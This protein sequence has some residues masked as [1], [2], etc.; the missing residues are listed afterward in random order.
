MPRYRITLE[1]DGTPFVGW[2]TQT[3]GKSVQGAITDAIANFAGEATSVRGAGR[4]DAGVHAAGQVAHFDLARDWDPL[5]LREA[6]NHHLKAQLIAVLECVVAAP[7]FDARFSATGRAYLYRILD[8]R[9]PPALDR[10]RVWWQAKRL[11]AEAMHQAAQVLI[12]T[13]D[14]TTFRAAACQ[15]ASPIKTL[16]RLDV[17]R[18]GDEVHVHA[19]ARSFLHNQ[20]RSIVG[21]LKNV[22]HGRWTT[23]DLKRTLD[24]RD[25]A[26]CGPVAPPGGLYLVGVMYPE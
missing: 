21:S 5:K 19:A 12:G 14:F 26:A 15:A 16:D 6:L 22:G 1:Y 25:R 11:N 7:D 20:V 4:T 23:Q 3:N 13:H 10:N 18:R 24:A 2:Q 9:A 17:I 8:R